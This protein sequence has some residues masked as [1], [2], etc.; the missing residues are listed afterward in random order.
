MTRKQVN[1]VNFEQELIKGSN[2]MLFRRQ[3]N[4][5]NPAK[6]YTANF[7]NPAKKDMTEFKNPVKYNGYFVRILVKISQN[8]YNLEII[9]I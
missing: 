9:K 7:K 5:K 1:K 4:F 3:A 6:K 2:E 8:E